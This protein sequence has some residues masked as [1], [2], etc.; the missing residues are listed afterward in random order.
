MQRLPKISEDGSQ[1]AGHVEQIARELVAH[2]GSG[3][4]HHCRLDA[5][6]SLA[7]NTAETLLV[8]T[9]PAAERTLQRSGRRPATSNGSATNC[10]ATRPA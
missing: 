5:V 6:S 2:P 1:T 4:Q 7:D 10:G 3:A 8:E 9:L